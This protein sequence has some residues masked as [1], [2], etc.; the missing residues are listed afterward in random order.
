MISFKNF[1]TKSF[2]KEV[3]E[4]FNEFNQEQMPQECY[5]WR[6]WKIE[7]AFVK[8]S[9]GSLKHLYNKKGKDFEDLNKLFYEFKQVKNAFK[10]TETPE[11]TIKNFYKECLGI[12]EKTFDYLIVFDAERKAIGIY[13]WEYVKDQMKVNDAKIT[14]KLNLCKSLEFFNYYD[15]I[16]ED[17]TSLSWR[18]I[19]GDK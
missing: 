3:D 19:E 13:D 12:S 6:S 2:F 15:E 1:D 8:H 4:I 17:T 11:I 16:F 14:V 10:N 18:E 7:R 9:N 5:G